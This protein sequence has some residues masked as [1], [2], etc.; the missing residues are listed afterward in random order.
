[1]DIIAAIKSEME[2]RAVLHL[3]FLHS[4]VGTYKKPYSLHHMYIY[5]VYI[6]ILNY[7]A[8]SGLEDE[9]IEEIKALK[10][11]NWTITRS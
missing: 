7:S 11:Y 6:I 10:T 9:H 4:Q 3:K 2:L 1:M 8:I 5:F